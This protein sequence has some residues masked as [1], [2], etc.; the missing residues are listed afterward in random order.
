MNERLEGRVD[1]LTTQMAKLAGKIEA[2][3]EDPRA[4]DWKARWLECRQSLV[5]I[6]DH[7]RET[8]SSNPAGVKIDVPTAPFSLKGA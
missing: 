4:G 1:R 3:P 5:N 2:A 6:R 8:I 7:G